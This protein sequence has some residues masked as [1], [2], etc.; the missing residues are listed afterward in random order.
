MLESLT[1]KHKLYRV[2]EG[3]TTLLETD[4]LEEA[5]HVQ[6]MAHLR[7]GTTWRA[8][9]EIDKWHE[10]DRYLGKAG[11]GDYKQLSPEDCWHCGRLL[12][13]C[14]CKLHVLDIDLE[15]LSYCEKRGLWYN[16]PLWIS[17]WNWV[18]WSC[19]DVSCPNCGSY[20]R[21]QIGY[22]LYWLK[23]LDCGYMEFDD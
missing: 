16:D 6:K 13:N 22:D 14:K 2:R 21:V 10:D 7:T 23:C 1:Q 5:I 20:Q 8:Y 17:F 18:S 19:P 3:N 4:D 11:Y 9:H 12:K 15:T